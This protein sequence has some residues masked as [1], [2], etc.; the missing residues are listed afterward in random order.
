MIP[1]LSFMFMCDSLSAVQ[2]KPAKKH[3]KHVISKINNPAIMRSLIR[4]PTKLIPNFRL[5]SKNIMRD[6]FH[7]PQRIFS[8]AKIARAHHVSRS[9]MTKRGGS[10]ELKYVKSYR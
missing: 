10:N 5:P 6:I 7:A 1:Y 2:P 8:F 4:G 3:A 9:V